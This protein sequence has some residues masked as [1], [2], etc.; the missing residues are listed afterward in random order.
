MTHHSTVA[1]PGS[2]DMSQYVSFIDHNGR[3]TI[4]RITSDFCQ[5]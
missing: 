3:F 2:P 4:A 1:L 5:T